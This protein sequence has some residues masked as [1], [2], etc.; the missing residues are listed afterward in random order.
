MNKQ[1]L[2][3]LKREVDDAK[4]EVTR[5]EG[6]LELLMKDLKEKHGCSTIKAA[7][8][9]L[10]K[11]Q[12]EIDNLEEQIKNGIAELEERYEIED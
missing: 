4:N 9:V 3:D 1:D 7:E 8:A 2:L 10:E 6:Q 5:L 12:G 11:T